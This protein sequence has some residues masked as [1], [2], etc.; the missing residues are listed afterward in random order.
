[1]LVRTE[2]DNREGRLKPAMLASMLIESK[3]VERLVVP[4]SAVVRENYEDHV[5]VAESD[6]LFRLVKVKLGP[7]QGGARV[8]LSGLKGGEKLVIEGAFHLNNERNRK[9]M[10]GA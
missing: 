1:V 7:E 10:E 6:G 5:F 9:E 8:L 3:P 4:A 2:L